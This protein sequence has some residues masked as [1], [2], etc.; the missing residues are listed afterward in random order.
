MAGTGKTRRV[1][2]TEIEKQYVRLM[3]YEDGSAVRQVALPLPEEEPQA[4]PQVSQQ[5]RRNRARATSISVGYVLFLTAVCIL[6]VFVCI[7]YLQLKSK[8]TTQY[9]QIAAL[10][11]DLNRVR[12]DNDAYYKHALASVSL[13]DVRATAVEKLGMRTAGVSQIRYYSA[14]DTGSYVRQYQEVPD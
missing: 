2:S 4:R 13:G 7:N 11:L 10:E 14:D 5:T 9:E 8:L 6:T 12:A 3:T 1:N